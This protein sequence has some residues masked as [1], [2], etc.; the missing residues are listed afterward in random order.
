MCAFNAPSLRKEVN[1][2]VEQS[3]KWLKDCGSGCEG[4]SEM[5]HTDLSKAP[6]NQTL[7]IVM[8]NDAGW[9]KRFESMGIR[10]GGHIRKIASQPFGGPIVIEVS[11]SKMS[12]GRNIAAKI[13]VEVLS[14]SSH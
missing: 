1:P 13:E 4:I 9:E 8:I 5:G 3:G 12:F 7:E 10:K 6:C 11:G 2:K 14:R